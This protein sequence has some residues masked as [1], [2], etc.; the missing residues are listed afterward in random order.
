VELRRIAKEKDLEKERKE[1]A[2]VVRAR[3]AVDKN[4]AEEEERIKDLR[5][6]KEADRSKTV[7]LTNAEATAQE[8]MVQELK[9]AE[10]QQ[11]IA[12][13]EARKRL[14]MAEAELEAADKGAKAKQ[15]LAEGVQAEAAAPGLAEARVK[16][17]RAV[18]VEKE[19]MAEARVMK[20][21]MLAEA[22]GL[23][24]KGMAE[25]RVKE[26]RASAVEKEGLVEARVLKEKML[27][28]ALGRQEQ[29]MAH[30]RVQQGE[31]EAIE[32]RGAAEAQTIERKLV[33]EAKGLAEK[34]TAMKALDGVG[35]EHEEF[36]L[37]L[38]AMQSVQVEQI[39]AQRQIAEA[40]SRVLAEAFKS[41]DINIVGGDG[42]FFQQLIQAITLG[43]AVDGFMDHSETAK[44]LLSPYLEGEA[45][46]PADV[47]DI[48][49]RPALGSGDLQNLS[50]AALLGK[51]AAGSSGEQRSKLQALLTKAQELG[52]GEKKG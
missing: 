4:V 35:R 32:K 1:I 13:F 22:A 39:H 25:A 10:G 18:A 26:S 38:Q 21:K 36:R 29:G 15:R 43:Q 37:R 48:L 20:E 8:K 51:L 41:A 34:A 17:I 28:E 40:Q 27:S 24:E 3:I 31:A 23:E 7:R 44:K 50:V 6:F 11:E 47:K 42:Q 45:S 52:L 9:A 12:K 14:T 30:V 16:E 2:D 19:G 46:L 49:S 33:A 5:A